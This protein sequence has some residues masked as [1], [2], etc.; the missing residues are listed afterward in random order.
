MT[1]ETTIK[2]KRGRPLGSIGQRNRR[3]QLAQLYTEMLGGTVTEIQ[4]RDITRAVELQDL[5]EKK[6]AE[7]NKQRK[8]SADELLALAG[9]EAAAD[10]AMRRAI[11]TVAA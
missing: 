11:N 2:A 6:R 4:A 1:S 3:L 7:L 5:A 10:A 9:I 8:I